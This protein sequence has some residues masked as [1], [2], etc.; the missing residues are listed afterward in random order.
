M[1]LSERLL[2]IISFVKSDSIVLD[3]GTDHGYIPVYLTENGIS[4]KVI[5]SDISSGS[6]KKAKQYAKLRG[7]EHKID[8]RLG[9]GL[10]VLKPYEVDTVIIAGMGG[11]LIK[12]ILENNYKKAET[13][14]N[15][16]LQPMVASKEL[17]MYLYNNNF[18]II[19][20]M[21]VIEEDKYYEIISA[22]WGKDF[23]EDDIFYE[24]SKPL[25]KRRDPLLKDY[26][27]NKIVKLNEII[28]SLDIE[29]SEKA[30]MR[31]EELSIEINKYKDVL[32]IYESY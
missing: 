5:A 10:E 23:I 16:I 17:R 3:I 14:N 9:N 24:F 2:G 8:I 19:D 11:F 25:L 4:K 13:I 1:N 15:F 6:L 29:K 32:S 30:Q 28:T 18:T 12:E 27:Q 22:K 21:I 7:L 31:K 26:I 20:E